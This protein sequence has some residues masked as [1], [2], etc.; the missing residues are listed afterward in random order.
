MET[1]VKKL[2]FAILCVGVLLSAA[3]ATDIYNNLASG[4]DGNDPVG[5][6]GPIADSFSTGA[7]GFTV[8]QV[9]LLMSGDNTSASGFSVYLLGDNGTAPGSVLT[10]FGTVADSSLTASLEPL[11]LTLSSPYALAANS[12]YWIEVSG[13]T[14]SAFWSWSMDQNALGVAGEYFFNDSGVNPNSE[15]AYQ[16]QLSGGAVPEPGSVLLL[17]SGLLGAVAT[18]RRKLSL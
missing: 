15:G 6:L 18:L 12:R 3:N 8:D 1:G 2:L 17:G 13:N 14:T 11:T 9:T 10:A 4:S 16:M 7:G 5:L